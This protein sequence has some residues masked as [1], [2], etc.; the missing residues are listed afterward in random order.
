MQR[1][2]YSQDKGRSYNNLCP[3]TSYRYALKISMFIFKLESGN[4]GETQEEVKTCTM[5]R[6]ISEWL[7][8][9]FR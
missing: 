7:V 5:Q 3:F 4:N 9:E 1:S 8:D 6:D 2:C